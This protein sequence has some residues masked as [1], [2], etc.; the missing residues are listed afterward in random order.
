[1]LTYKMAIALRPY[2]TSLQPMYTFAVTARA[3]YHV[4]YA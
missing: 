1:V 3:P 2:V 4:T